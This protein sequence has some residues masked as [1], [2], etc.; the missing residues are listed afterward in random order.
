MLIMI[1][2]KEWIHHCLVGVEICLFYNYNAIVVLLQ[3]VRFGEIY[4]MKYYILSQASNAFYTKS[5]Y[6]LLVVHN[7]LLMISDS[8]PFSLPI[9][10]LRPSPIYRN[11][12]KYLQKLIRSFNIPNLEIFCMAKLQ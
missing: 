2:I 3:R 10:W 11:L 6:I 4:S 5:W 1:S 12:R 9:L 8:L 7:L